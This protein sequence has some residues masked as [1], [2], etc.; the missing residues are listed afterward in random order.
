MR[1]RTRLSFGSIAAIVLWAGFL[2]LPFMVPGYDS[3]RETVSLIGEMSSPARIPFAAMLCLLAACLLI[4]S[5]GLRDVSKML[6]LSGAAANLTT[7]MAV[8]SAGVGIFAFPHPLHNVFGLS[9][10]VGYQAPWV[11]AMTWRREQRFHRVVTF[12]WLMGALLWCA[13][14]ANLGA[15][16]FHSWLWKIEKPEYGLVQRTLFLTWSVWLAG[17]SIML[18]AHRVIRDES[19]RAALPATG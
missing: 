3:V 1:L 12:S 17:V 10:I 2:L 5:S 14:M 11:L 7:M 6:G 13:I 16:D 8:S 18:M 19:A 15:I 9:E 4:F